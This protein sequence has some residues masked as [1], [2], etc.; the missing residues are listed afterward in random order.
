MKTNI[1]SE[2]CT[3]CG[4]CAEKCNVDAIKLKKNN[5]DEEIAIIDLDKCID[6]Q[7]C[8]KCCPQEAPANMVDILECYAAWTKNEFDY[9]TTSSGGIAT[10]LSKKVIIEGG[11]VYGSAYLNGEVKHIR[12]DCI[13][14]L[15]KIKGS[16][17]VQS[18]IK[19]CYRMLK[20]D[21]KNN[22]LIFFI[23]TPCQ[24]AAVKKYCGQY[25]KL[26]TSDLI[27][28]GTPPISYFNDYI[29][30]LFLDNNNLRVSFRNKRESLKICRNDTIIYDK[31]Y[32]RDYYFQA[33]MDGLIFRENCY[34]CQY[35]NQKRVGD[36]SIGDFWGLKRQGF[37][38]DV[39]EY[40]SCVL[41]NTLNGKQM[42]ND[43]KNSCNFQQRTL[44]EA[45]LGNTNLRHASVRPKE[46]DK[47]NMNYEKV[48]FVKALKKSYLNRKIFLNKVRY[49]CLLP[50][51]IIR[52]GKSF[53]A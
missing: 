53:K 13:E 43:I 11:V 2:N 4:L 25:N 6:C 33:F 16:K 17:Y 15:E 10:E 44:E 32:D 9:A 20:E 47:F 45:V 7:A 23:G 40:V 38:Y 28:H 27:C 21:M 24:V 51:R 42:F 50:Y 29:S 18:T 12:I 30:Y 1:V 48:G 8:K 36:I 35:A 19:E 5:L 52:Y 41:I 14:N 3:G 49:F 39:P 26:L 37:S 34:K 22:K 46:K 31:N